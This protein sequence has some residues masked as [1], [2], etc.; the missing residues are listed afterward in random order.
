YF[1]LATDNLYMNIFWLSLCLGG[2][3]LSMGMSWAT[4]T[5]LGR[6][7]SG[8]VSGW[9]N[10]WGNIGA[11]LSPILAGLLADKIGWTMTLQLMMVP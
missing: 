6:N 10:L 1:A 4:A 9:M 8:T 2:V 3:G 5:D 11:L 7:F